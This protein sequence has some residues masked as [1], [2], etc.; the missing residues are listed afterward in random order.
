MSDIDSFRARP[1][2]KFVKTT[3]KPRATKNR[4]GELV[5]PP[6]PPPPPED[7]AAAGAGEVAE[8]GGIVVGMV[9]VDMV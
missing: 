6:P 9:E 4:S 1:Y 3:P 7:V 2:H 5:G 8:G